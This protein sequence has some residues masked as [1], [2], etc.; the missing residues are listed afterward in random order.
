LI[1][2]PQKRSYT[3]IGDAVNTASR[4]ESMTKHLGASILISTEVAQ[5]LSNPS[6][7]LLRRLGK[8]SPKGRHTSVEIVDIMG[9]DDGSRFALA[10]KQEIAAV[11]KALHFFSQRQFDG[12]QDAFMAL[13]QE[14][15]TVSH[16]TRAHGYWFLAET[17][18]KYGRTPLPEE[19]G[20]PS[21]ALPADWDGTII[22]MEK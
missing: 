18:D 15:E 20:Y 11:D 16:S 12:A 8:Y 5:D 2:S 1:G 7:L 4:L 14:A 9:E 3:V 13:A 17:A 19:C 6:R 10:I 21:L 22:M